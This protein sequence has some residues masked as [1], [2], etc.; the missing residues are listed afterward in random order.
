MAEEEVRV[1]SSTGGQKGSKGAR[2]DLIPTAPLEAL[3]RHY[4][5]GA[6]KYEQVNGRDNWRNGYEW[7][8]SY[9][10]LQRHLAAFWSGEDIDEETGSAH[11]V[12][13]AWHAFTLLEFMEHYPELDDRQDLLYELG[14][15]DFAASQP[16]VSVGVLLEPGSDYRQPSERHDAKTLT[17]PM[18]GTPRQESHGLAAKWA[19]RG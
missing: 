5:K 4:G 1:T 6:A 19:G 11:L 2:Y 10:A 3:A 8:L 17:P 13:A 9:A 18:I 12:A 16:R 14:P 7:S 15:C